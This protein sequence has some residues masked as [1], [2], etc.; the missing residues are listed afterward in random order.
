MGLSRNAGTEEG[1]APWSCFRFLSWC[2]SSVSMSLLLLLL[3]GVLAVPLPLPLP[4]LPLTLSLTPQPIAPSLSASNRRHRDCP[5][6]AHNGA[7]DRSWLKMSSLLAGLS[8]PRIPPSPPSLAP[9]SPAS[10]SASA[11]TPWSHSSTSKNSR[12]TGSRLSRA[13]CSPS[14]A[15]RSSCC[16]L[17]STADATEASEA[18]APCS[19]LKCCRALAAKLTPSAFMNTRLSFCLS[20]CL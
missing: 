4:P 14:R 8:V 5:L 18:S 19:T 11:S 12:S 13:R 16:P 15:R 20:I 2:P 6:T 7:S 10:A 3:L 9:A 17:M 1:A